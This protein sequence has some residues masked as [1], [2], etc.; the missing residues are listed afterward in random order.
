M[1]QVIV[2]HPLAFFLILVPLG[3]S[4]LEW[5]VGSRSRAKLV[6]PTFTWMPAGAPEPRGWMRAARLFRLAA[7]ICLTL[8]TAGLCTE[9]VEWVPADAAA[10]VVIV[11][12]ASS[13]MTAEDFAPQNRLEEAKKH[14][15]EF[16]TRHAGMDIGLVQFAA[17]PRLL[18]PA[19]SDEQAVLD[20][21]QRVQAAG[22]G[23]D[24]TAIGNALASSLNRLRGGFWRRRTILLI[25]DGVNNRGPIAPLDAARI[26]G[27]LD[28]PIF[29]VGIGTDAVSRF[30]VPAAPGST[31]QVEAR[32][33]IDDAAL[34]RL[35][36]ETGGRYSRVRN[37]EELRRALADLPAL[38]QEQASRQRVSVDP[39]LPRSL[40]ALALILL[41]AEFVMANF[42]HSE[43]PG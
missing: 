16:I 3:L 34:E 27:A 43:I 30:Y 31:T 15:A 25:T 39:R 36:Q 5:L 14:L 24:G 13:S 7:M 18:V 28:T 40:A 29:A 19:T 1:S 35:A 22:F 38:E 21:L 23:E 20:A 26:A 33:E 37:S 32:I 4:L 41:C 9:R 8:L 17:S 11:L 6:M 12:D 42:M 10:A 2:S